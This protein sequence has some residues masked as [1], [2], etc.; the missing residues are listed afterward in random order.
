MEA[1]IFIV[2]RLTDPIRASGINK[3]GLGFGLTGR[4]GR[5]DAGRKRRFWER[6][7]NRDAEGLE[8]GLFRGQLGSSTG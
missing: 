1:Q 6:E 2:S 3:D 4:C 8:E 5:E 7:K